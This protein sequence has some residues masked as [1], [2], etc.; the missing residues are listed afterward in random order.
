MPF[1]RASNFYDLEKVRLDVALRL[2]AGLQHLQLTRL[3]AG[4]GVSPWK[5]G[6]QQAGAH[7]HHRETG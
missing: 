3:C 1:L 2:I 7:A 4:N 5:D 6:Q